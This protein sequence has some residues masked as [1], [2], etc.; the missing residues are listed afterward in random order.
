MWAVRSTRPI[1]ALSLERSGVRVLVLLQVP[2]VV[3]VGVRVGFAAVRVG[4]VV[5]DVVVGVRAVRVS[6]SHVAVAVLV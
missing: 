1:Q 3:H 5:L 2:R 6:V 4:V